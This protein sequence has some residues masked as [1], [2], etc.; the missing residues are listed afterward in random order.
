MLRS[1]GSG[2]TRKG[3]GGAPSRALDAA[4]TR[5]HAGDP[6]GALSACEGLIAQ[7][8]GLAAA[9]HLMGACLEA[10]GRPLHAAD[11]YGRASALDASALHLRDHAAALTMVGESDAAVGVWREASSKAARGGRMDAPTRVRLEW[12]AS[13]AELWTGD[14]E[15][16]AARAGAAL[17]D[18]RLRS[19]MDPPAGIALLAIR[20]E[21]VVRARGKA[22]DADAAREALDTVRTT[23]AHAGD[24]ITAAGLLG[25]EALYGSWL[26]RTDRI[27]E[28]LHA[29]VV[30]LAERAAE[31]G[32]C[33]PPIEFACK[34]LGKLE[35]TRGNLEAAWSA[36]TLGN[37]VGNG[38]VSG[39]R[40]WS[41]A[42]HE[43]SIRQRLDALR[44]TA[45]LARA[46]AG[47]LDEV[48]PGVRP[49]LIVGMPRSGT[50][51]VEQ[52]IAAHPR[53][54]GRGELQALW[55]AGRWISERTG[56]PIDD[57]AYLASVTGELATEAG[58]RYMARHVQ[59]MQ[60]AG[61]AHDAGNP[62]I[63]TDKMPGNMEHLHIAWQT[64]PG[65]KV[66]WC[67]RDPADVA[68]SCWATPFATDLAWSRDMELL[69][70]YTRA[71]DRQLAFWR[72]S[73]LLDVHVVKYE[74]MVGDPEGEA[75]RLLA[76]LGLDW[77]ASVLEFWRKGRRVLTA[78]SEQATLPIYATSIGRARRFGI[79]SDVRAR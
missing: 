36:Y 61:L 42:A 26:D 4:R 72:S 2:G 67:V 7:W 68:F 51:L 5:L 79:A 9:H 77:D 34:A 25:T 3:A 33:L 24:E 20:A 52:V 10:A 76:F 43:A 71:H 38:G 78:S 53:A 16:A 64:L 55:N 66:V 41:V 29:E 31:S 45:G 70:A 19:V 18:A 47:A 48:A 65:A 73:G 49:V 59:A 28:R 54:H 11:A 14:Y 1:T 37:R 32:R 27:R 46:D 12:A 40:V 23:A 44:D 62:A 35:E 58:R 30:P 21:A 63:V 39:E 22:G 74:S 56:V 8:P 13:E 15:G 75:K 6:R 50:S 57:R 17:G 69:S 60:S